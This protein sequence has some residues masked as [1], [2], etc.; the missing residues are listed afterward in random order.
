MAKR[1]SKKVSVRPSE[2]ANQPADPSV[3][4]EPIDDSQPTSGAVDPVN[5]STFPIVGIVASAGGLDSFKSFFR[6]IKENCGMAFVLVPHLD[7]KRKSSLVEL[8]SRESCLPVVEAIDGMR[9]KI[10][11][12]YVIPHNHTLMLSQGVIR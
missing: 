10:D 12:V 2:K 6:A 5:E 4:G 9:V 11:S 8:L 7:S 1:H 3:N